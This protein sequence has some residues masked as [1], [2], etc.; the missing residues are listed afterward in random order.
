MDE[1]LTGLREIDRANDTPLRDAVERIGTHGE[2]FELDAR[3]DSNGHIEATAEGTKTLGGGW[4]I[5]AGVAY[6]K[7]QWYALGKLIWTPKP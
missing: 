4:S 5:S 6:A 2:G 3:R 7:E 1:I